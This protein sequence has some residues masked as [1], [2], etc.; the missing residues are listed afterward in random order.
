MV[1]PIL[2]LT[3]LSLILLLI[4]YFSCLE[5]QINM[6]RDM[7]NER[8]LPPKLPIVKIKNE[9]ETSREMGGLVDIVMHK[10]VTGHAYHIN[11]ADLIRAGEMLDFD[12]E[13][14]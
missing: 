9:T 12:D 10:K 7:L 1:L 8:L 3:I 2:I 13:E 11:A 5:G 6:H 4:F 14:E